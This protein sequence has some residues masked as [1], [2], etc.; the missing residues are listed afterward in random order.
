MDLSKIRLA[1]HSKDYWKDEGIY[2]WRRYL[3]NV[4][5]LKKLRAENRQL[6]I[7]L[8]DYVN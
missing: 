5:M 8:S 6:R 4:I 3:K 7:L 2:W 1:E